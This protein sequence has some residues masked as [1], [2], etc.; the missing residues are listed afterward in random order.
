MKFLGILLVL[1]AIGGYT[2]HYREHHMW[3]KVFPKSDKWRWA[4][5]DFIHHYKSPIGDITLASDG[6][7]LVE[8]WFDG[9][10]YFAEHVCGH[11]R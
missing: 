10:K 6:K 8:L 7:A 11:V 2:W 3:D 4:E 9:Q 5:M 1:A